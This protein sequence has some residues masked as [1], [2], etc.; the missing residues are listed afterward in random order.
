MQPAASA[1]TGPRRITTASI[2]QAVFARA[3]SSISNHRSPFI[4][5]IVPNAKTVRE[6]RKVLTL[7]EAKQSAAAR[8][9][10]RRARGSKSANENRIL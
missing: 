5:F 8:G 7:E 10:S 6:H 4:K 3:R 1:I 9:R 2:Q